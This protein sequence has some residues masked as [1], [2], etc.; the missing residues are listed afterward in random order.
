MKAGVEADIASGCP[1]HRVG[2]DGEQ[3]HKG[4]FLRA[5]QG[6]AQAEGETR[7]KESEGRAK[8]C[9]GSG[10]SLGARGPPARGKRGH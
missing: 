9:E 10:Q 5:F 7:V 4:S 3:G 6:S 1:A 8:K 2:S